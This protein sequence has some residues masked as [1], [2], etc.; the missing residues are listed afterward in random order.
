[1]P[2]LSVVSW[3]LI[4]CL[5]ALAAGAIIYYLIYWDKAVLPP[6]VCRTA[7]MSAI[8]RQ[9]RQLQDR[10]PAALQ[11]KRARAGAPASYDVDRTPDRRVADL[12]T[13]RANLNQIEVTA[14]QHALLDMANRR[15]PRENPH[16]R[17]SSA[18]VPYQSAYA[19][20][21][22]NRGHQNA[23]AEVSHA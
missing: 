1:M 2:T 22:M 23:G 9:T 15:P 18:F 8:E 7:D 3:I 5:A 12:A 13:F 19:R 21:W 20:T 6:T 14:A 17:G 10:T 16:P 4:S 11:T